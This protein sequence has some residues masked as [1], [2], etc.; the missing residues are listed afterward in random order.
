MVIQKSVV[1]YDNFI[2]SKISRINQN[3][4][5]FI[6]DKVYITSPTMTSPT[7]TSPTMTSP[8]YDLTDKKFSQNKL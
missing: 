4:F 5:S 8:T 2:C 7:M 3:Y 6:F 1:L